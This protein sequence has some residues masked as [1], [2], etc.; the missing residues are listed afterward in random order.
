MSTSLQII[1]I[2]PPA[3]FQQATTFGVPVAHMAY[4]IG[5]GG[6]LYRADI[7]PSLQGGL[8]VLNNHDFDGRGDPAQLCRAII[9][10]CTAR[11][12]NGILCD[13]D[14]PPSPFLEK[15]AAQLG[16]LAFQRGWQL[17]STEGCTGMGEYTTALIPTA[18]SS[19]SLESRLKGAINQYGIDRVALAAQRTAQEFL[20][21][22]G[23]DCGRPLEPGELA[24][25]VRRFSPAIF[26]D[27]SL[28]THYFTYMEQ[29]SAHFILF[30]DSGSMLRKLSLAR[31]LGIKN[32]F[33][34][35][36]EVEDIL[37][38]LLG[39]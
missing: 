27:S 17:Y 39:G 22:A 3:N 10:E 26:F 15:T 11:K 19:G 29:G 7:P 24:E 28:C 25:R 14:G 6:R 9:R 21:P 37:P 8:M 31:D 18:I 13:F 12:F 33:L 23:T 16:A 38:R 4:R 36:P 20:L 5:P 30:D 1:L 32:I 2:T 35:F 34:T